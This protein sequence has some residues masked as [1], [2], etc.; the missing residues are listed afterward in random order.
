MTEQTE[1][2]ADG[3]VDVD[4]DQKQDQG[5][6]EQLG[7]AGKKALDAMKAD[8]K[9][10]Q[11]EARQAKKA[12]EVLQA[13]LDAL[14]SGKAPD[15]TAKAIDD[16]KREA[17]EAA[18]AKANARIVRAELKVA[19]AGKLADP[20]DAAA[21]IDADQFDVG[22]DGEVDTKEL[23]DAIAD[24]LKRKPHLAAKQKASFGQVEGGPRGS[25][26][27]R[28]KSIREAYARKNSG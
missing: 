19:A 18:T 9:A 24:L 14:E 17:T 22:D 1:V 27:A 28:P 5:D 12:L 11:I 7:D 13:K 20:S 8:R 6:A 3:D 15:E 10:A 26:S 4:E 21:F 16:A 23:A 2:Q 25:G